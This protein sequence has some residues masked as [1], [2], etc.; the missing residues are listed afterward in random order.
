MET[1]LF[2]VFCIL[3][4]DSA[5]LKTEPGN[6]ESLTSCVVKMIEDISYK[7]YYHVMDITVMNMNNDLKLSALHKVNG[8]RFV[9]RRFFW[10]PGNINNVIYIVMSES[11]H[12]LQHGLRK[13]TSDA[14]WNPLARFIIVLQ[15]F[16]ISS[17]REITDLLHA[18]NIYNV[19]VISRDGN[20]YAIYKYNFT[21]PDYCL[22]SGHLTFW[23]RCFDYQKEKNIPFLNKGSIRNC[24]FKFL[25]RNIWPLVNFDTSTK[26]SEQYFM[27]LFQK[28]FGLQIDLQEF[29]KVDKYGK[30]MSNSTLI[31]LQKVENNEIEGVLGGYEISSMYSGNISHTYPITIDHM[32]HIVAH[33]K[34]VGQLVAILRQSFYTCII[35]GILYVI[36]C[37]AV[38]LLS[39]FSSPKDISRNALIVFGYLCNTNVV[40]RTVSGWPQI[41]IFTSLL[42]AA[43]I[44]PYAIQAN[45]YSVTT[46][47]V[48]DYEPKYEEDLK[49]YQAVLHTDF[50]YRSKFDGYF[51]CGTRISCLLLVKD[52][53]NKPFYTILSNSH[54]K[55]YQWQLTDDHCNMAMY[56]LKEPYS[57]IYR[58][59]YLR[60][61]SLLIP[62]FNHFIY[63]YVTTGVMQKLASDIYFREWLKCK[64]RH[65]PEHISL[66]LSDFYYVFMMLIGGYCLSL[67]L[68]IFEVWAGTQCMF[69]Q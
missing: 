25:S 14:F 18:H 61:G 31:M 63:Q 50:Q 39:I 9:S 23:S 57:T 42:F 52:Y 65:R 43:F 30:V 10:V 1:F 34:Y 66:P 16:E 5:L 22:K 59:F 64:S 49:N 36:F 32:F 17:L 62:Y 24:R 60:R 33:A 37:V 11:Y 3:F 6:V 28:Q 68:F 54:F 51:D 27:A 8:A 26:G 41:L 69:K 12:E 56:Q 53:P 19:S 29:G 47:P 35:I 7:K 21:K 4:S 44:I 48:R 46:Q 58:A 45:L 2:T 15:S 38:T 40:R 67:L 55:V 20:D 13:V